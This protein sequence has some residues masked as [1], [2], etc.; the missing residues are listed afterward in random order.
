LFGALFFLWSAT[1]ATT[2]M[3]SVLSAAY[4]VYDSRPWYKVRAVALGLT[5]CLCILLVVALAVVLFGGHIA[6]LLSTKMG[7]GN[8]VLA[9]WQALQWM[10]ALF[11]LSLAFSLVYYFGPDVKEQ[12][13]Y[14][15]TPGSVVG[16]LV[17]LL[18]S[19]GFRAYLH[20]FNNYGKTYGSLGAVIILLLW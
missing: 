19:L 3:M 8:I 10:L 5:L 9:S 20:Y 2:T 15:I 18:A 7:A 14:W 17:W 13:W 1:T 16:V 11:V 6:Q 4:H 12:R